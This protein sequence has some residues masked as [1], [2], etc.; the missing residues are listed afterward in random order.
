M[1]VLNIFNRNIRDSNLHSELKIRERER[2]RERERGLHGKTMLIRITRPMRLLHIV[3]TNIY[4]Y[5]VICVG[6][7]W[8]VSHTKYTQ[9][10]INGSTSFAINNMYYIN[11]R[12]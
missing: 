9:R 7:T 5:K 2:E 3:C 8:F 10:K 4:I 1:T 12:I 6:K 11:F